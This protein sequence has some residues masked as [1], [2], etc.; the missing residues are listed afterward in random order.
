MADSKPS[1]LLKQPTTPRADILRGLESIAASEPPEAETAAEEFNLSYHDRKDSTRSSGVSELYNY[2][3]SSSI[4]TQFPVGVT[5][6]A[7]P[8][9][10]RN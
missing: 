2:S 5:T 1:V 8:H 6:Q 7:V 9:R 10:R 4:A 3:L